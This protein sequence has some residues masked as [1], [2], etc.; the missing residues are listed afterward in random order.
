MPTVNALVPPCNLYDRKFSVGTTGAEMLQIKK[1]TKVV[2]M[3]M[4]LIILP[5]RCASETRAMVASAGGRECDAARLDVVRGKQ[6]KSAEVKRLAGD[7]ISP[8]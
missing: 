1:K 2:R 3:K 7:V 4:R 5:F 6:K 8:V